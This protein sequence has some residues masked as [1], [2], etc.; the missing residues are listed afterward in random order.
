MYSMFDLF[1]D[2]PAYRPVYVISE[3]EMKELQKTQQEEEL[4]EIIHQRERLK[5]AYKAQMKHIDDREK[6]LRTKLKVFKASNKK[7]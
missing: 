2:V 5:E 7:V 4:D 1:F 3:S 6:E